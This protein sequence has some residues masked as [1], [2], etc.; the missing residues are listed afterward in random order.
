MF[1][2]WYTILFGYSVFVL[3]KFDEC[4]ISKII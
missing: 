3:I 1:K 2:I 4:D